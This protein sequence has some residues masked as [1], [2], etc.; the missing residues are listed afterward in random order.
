MPDI[1][2]DVDTAVQ[3]P[4]NVLPLID[5]TDFKTIED[6]I[7]YNEAGM[8]VVWNFVTAAGVMTTTDFTPTTSGLHDWLEEGTNRGMYS[9]EIPASTGTVNNDAEGFGWIS[10]ETTNCLAFRGPIIGFR[11]AG[12]NDVLIESAYSATRGLTGTALPDAVVNTAG[13]MATSAGGSVGIDDL[14]TAVENR[15]EMDSNSTELAKIGTIPA[16]DGAGQTIGAA[17]AKLADDN[18]GADFDAGTDS[19]Q[20]IRDR[21]DAAWVT[22]ATAGTAMALTAGAVDDI[23][24]EVITKAAHDVS[25]S[26]AKKLRG[27]SDQVIR[28]ETAQG[29]G[30]GN[31]QIQLDAGA[32]AV[33]GA[34]DPAEICIIAGTGAGQSRL[35]L[36]YDG[37]TVTATVDRDWKVNPANDS[38]YVI[39]CH[40]G[41]EHVNEGLAQAGAAN[42]ITLNTLADSNN[43]TYIGSIVFIR[44]GTGQDQSRIVT[45]YVGATRVATVDRTWTTNPD[46]TSGYVILPA[47]LEVLPDWADGGRL[48]LILDIIAAD[49]TTDIPAL[50]A[51]VQ[52][53]LDTITDTDGVILGAAG[54]DLVWDEVLTGATHNVASSSG[55]RLRQVEALFLLDTGTAQAGAAGSLTLAAGANANDD[56]FD[57]AIVVITGGTGAGQARAVNGYNGTSKVAITTPDWIVTPDNTSDYEILAD[58]EKHVY[59]V[60]ANAIA[61]GSI[62]ANAI[63]ASALATDA[64]AEIADGVW[65]EAKAGHVAG[66]SMGEEVQAHAL[67]SEVAT[68]QA[69][70]DILTGSDG[71]TLA[72]AQGNYAPNTVVPD[73]AGVAPTAAEIVDEFE[74]Q[75]QA[76][77][78]GFHVNVMEINSLSNPAVQLARSAGTIVNAAAAAGTLSPTQMTTTLTEV[79]DD[80]YNG[81]IITWTSGGLINAQ[82]DITDYDG[83]TKMLTFTGVVEA[84]GDGDTFVIS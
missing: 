20:A 78:T 23:W 4:C 31:N 84:P 74:T 42:T 2:M 50:I 71:A 65:D 30:T 40:P 63:S 15:Q 82:S 53:D 17:L 36:E 27:I 16:L 75:S 76:D 35:V 67:S 59:E 19:Q 70:L 61:V 11:A 68:A 47:Q 77:P 5:P 44:S 9:I 32:S 3:V 14:P 80:H 72:T 73:A 21:G 41:R 6:A 22:G 25:N 33:D 81:R 38:E 51:A 83:G 52:D 1:W 55:R 56:F 29:P 58:T 69:D 54:V 43:N 7:A 8:A 79:T 26:A 37:G 12:L 46:T 24:D 18:G 28:T 39:T 34:Y 62:A 10:G 45:A 13:G 57:H 60:H 49:T 48:D 64:V 66:G